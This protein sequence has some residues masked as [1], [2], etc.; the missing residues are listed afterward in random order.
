MYFLVAVRRDNREMSNSRKKRKNR[1]SRTKAQRNYPRVHVKVAV[2]E[3]DFRA[4]TRLI[5]PAVLYAD[6]VTIHSPAASLLNAAM[7]LGTI[8]DRRQ[9][10][11]AILE[12]IGKVPSLAG[13][14]QVSPQILEQIKIFLSVDPRIVRRAGRLFGADK[15]IEAFYEKLGEFDAIWEK[16]I[17][18]VLSDLKS[19]VGANELLDALANG[20][21]AVADLGPTSN[22]DYVAVALRAYTGDSDD[23]DLDRVLASFVARLV[24]ILTEHRSFPLLD[25]ASADLARSLEQGGKVEISTHSMRRGAEVSSAVSF[26]GFLP[27]FEYLAMDEILDLRKELQGP[28]VRFR[29]ALAT[30]SREFEMRPIDKSFHAELEEA[31]R[32]RVLPALTEIRETLA[33]HGLLKEIASIALGDP[34]RLM[35]EAGGVIATGHADVVSLPGLITAG[36]AA[37]LPI[38]DTVGRA[39]VKTLETRRDARKNAFFFLHQLEAEAAQRVK[40]S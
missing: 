30:V 4:A 1:R 27:S 19:K 36:L 14:L 38:A 12:I 37:A 32:Q 18:R 35:I 15:D 20:C 21:V 5:K 10:L 25:A 3:S 23:D 8:T 11:D 40:A 6:Q 2:A 24:E 28:L 34:R 16:E 13:E 7:S 26:M 29:A 39:L 9:Q 33:E 22:T 17:P 31:W